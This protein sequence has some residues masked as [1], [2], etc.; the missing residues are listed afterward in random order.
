M[1]SSPPSLRQIGF[2]ALA[3]LTLGLAVASLLSGFSDSFP[4]RLL[5]GLA[6]FGAGALILGGAVALALVRLAG[7]RDP[8]SEE[9]FDV[10]VERTEWLASNESWRGSEDHPDDED[11]DDD[12]DV[13]EDL[14]DPH[15]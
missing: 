6:V 15:N 4:L 11:E 13:D 10:L 8:E 2:S 1:S 5:E 3:A 7:W 9:D 14:F 12:E